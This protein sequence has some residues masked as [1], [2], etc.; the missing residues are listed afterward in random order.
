MH[1]ADALANTKKPAA[2]VSQGLFVTDAAA[3]AQQST[4]G[5]P[6]AAAPG[7]QQGV[8]FMGI[9]AGAALPTSAVPLSGE[10]SGGVTVCLCSKP[11]CCA[12]A[13]TPAPSI[14]QQHTLQFPCK[15]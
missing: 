4:A 10:T 5:G 1:H 15:L 12:V 3:Q 9:P 8:S 2:L 7:P 6:T 14:A 11:H 13:M